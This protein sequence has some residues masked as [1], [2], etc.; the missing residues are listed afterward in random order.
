MLYKSLERIC[1]L[2]ANQPK[3]MRDE[4]VKHDET[5]EMINKEVDANPQ[6]TFK[7]YKKWS[8]ENL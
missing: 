8:K 7:N 2:K 5:V 1:N 6:L 4:Q 3:I